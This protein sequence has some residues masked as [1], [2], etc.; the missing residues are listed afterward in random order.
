MCPF[1]P[2]T[3][4]RRATK[5]AHFRFSVAY[6]KPLIEEARQRERAVVLFALLL[7]CVTSY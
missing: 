3:E 4:T 7:A 1:F 6:N 2:Y 5:K